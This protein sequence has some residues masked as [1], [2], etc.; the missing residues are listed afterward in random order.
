[1]TALG[2]VRDGAAFVWPIWSQPLSRAG[3]EALL[4]RSDLARGIR[5]ER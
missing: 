3:I 5:W 1:M 2:A 4:G